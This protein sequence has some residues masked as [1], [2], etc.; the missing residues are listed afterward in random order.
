MSDTFHRPEKG[1]DKYTYIY[2]STFNN[3]YYLKPS[4][5]IKKLF[6]PDH[7][8][9][10]CLLRNICNNNRMVFLGKKYL[11]LVNIKRLVEVQ[12]FICKTI[13]SI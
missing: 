9:A 7:H 4:R 3:N 5:E 6:I 2:L 11:M 13:K 10:A 12:T 8:K 1:R